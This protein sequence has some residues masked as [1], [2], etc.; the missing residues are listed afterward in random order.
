MDTIEFEDAVN[1][2]KIRE[3]MKFI[4]QYERYA[5]ELNFM[6]EWL[7]TYNRMLKNG[8]KQKFNRHME[9]LFED[10]SPEILKTFTD[11]VHGNEL[12]FF[13]QTGKVDRFKRTITTY[14]NEL[15]D[16]L[17]E[18]HEKYDKLKELFDALLN[19]PSIS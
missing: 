5:A 12:K 14:H 18:N 19:M 16:W 17:N 11:A 15:H 7:Q 2:E 6:H 3:D 10:V 9:I 13:V 4:D 8:A 1:E